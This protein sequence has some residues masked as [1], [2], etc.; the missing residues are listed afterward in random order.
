MTNSQMYKDLDIQ[1]DISWLQNIQS[2]SDCECDSSQQISQNVELEQ[3]QDNNESHNDENEDKLRKM[4][5]LTTLTKIQCCQLQKL[6]P[7]N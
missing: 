3:L 1:L 4:K 5:I 2:N 7:E 6:Y